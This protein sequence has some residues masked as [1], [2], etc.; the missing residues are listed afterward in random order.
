MKYINKNIDNEPDAL[1]EF[2]NTTPNAS[3]DG[4]VDSDKE[5][6]EKGVLKKAL[7]NEQGWICC[8]CMQK[9]QEGNITVEHYITQ[10]HHPDS[11]Y[12]PQIHAANQL[13]F[14]NMLASC[15]YNNRNCSG[16]RGNVP[17]KSL[18]PRR[19]ETSERLLSYDLADGKIKSRFGD[20]DVEKELDILKLNKPGLPTA[21][22]T[23]MDTAWEL[24]KKKKN[25]QNRYWTKDDINEIIETYTNKRRDKNGNL[26]YH[27]YCMAVVHFLEEKKAR[28]P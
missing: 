26:A 9:L 27:A 1:R 19:A 11:P 14:L 8:Y 3:Y 24:L 21:R 2:R 12:L 5:T 25:L 17:L 23:A 7:A 6:G 10:A 15:N 4:Y 13:N 22:R 28:Y 20:A 16:E 18:D